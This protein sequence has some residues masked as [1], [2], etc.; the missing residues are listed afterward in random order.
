[1]EA[2]RRRQ[3]ATAVG[4]KLGTFKGDTCV[5]TFLAKF[6]NCAR[7]YRWDEEDQAFQLKAAL[8]GPAGLLLWSLGRDVKAD[9]IKEL[10]RQRFGNENQAERFRAELRSLRRGTGDSLQ[11]LYQEVYRL[12]ALAY[13]EDLTSKISSIVGRDAFLEALGNPRLRVRI[14]EREPRTLEDA[15]NA[16]TRLEAFDQGNVEDIP[17]AREDWSRKQKHVRVVQGE[18]S[19]AVN[20][21]STFEPE[22]E[23]KGMLGQ[24]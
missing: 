18:A 20:A 16:A 24:N 13:P 8:E 14:L 3:V 2:R 19:K 1:M 6:D 5:E 22:S 12:M 9:K 10:L 15:L 21:G 11:W 4:A 7:Y 17:P 23:V